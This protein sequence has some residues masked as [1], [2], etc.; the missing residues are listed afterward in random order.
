MASD[1]T[2]VV[3]SEMLVVRP[4]CAAVKHDSIQGRVTAVPGVERE[5]KG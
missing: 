4:S 5:R 1:T 2:N 3:K